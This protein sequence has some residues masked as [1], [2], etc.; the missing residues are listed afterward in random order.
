[1]EEQAQK[2]QKG[3]WNTEPDDLAKAKRPLDV[4]AN[5]AVIFEQHKGKAVTGKFVINFVNRICEAENYLRL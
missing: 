5:P 4:E 3:I 1:L 2:A